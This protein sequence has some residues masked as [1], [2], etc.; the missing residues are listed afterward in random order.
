MHIGAETPPPKRLQRELYRRVQVNNLIARGGFVVLTCFY[1]SN[2]RSLISLR[3]KEQNIE[4]VYHNHLVWVLT[5]VIKIF[6]NPLFWEA[7]G[8]LTTTVDR[9]Y[10]TQYLLVN[11][12]G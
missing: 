8:P 11:S 5:V 2:E 9:K 6:R 4:P 12:F 1:V 10:G 7:S 3:G